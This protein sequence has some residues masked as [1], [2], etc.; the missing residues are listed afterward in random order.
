MTTSP[1]TSARVASASPIGALPPLHS[2]PAP[3][4]SL[5]HCSNFRERQRLH[6]AAL[7][8]RVHELEAA[9]A[10]TAAASTNLALSPAVGSPT[11]PQTLAIIAENSILRNCAISVNFSPSLAPG[12]PGCQTCAVEKARTLIA[13]GQIHCLE[14]RISELMAEN[15]TL[16]TSAGHFSNA[17][18]VSRDFQ[19]SSGCADALMVEP[20]SQPMIVTTN[21]EVSP[22]ALSVSVSSA[23]DEASLRSESS[24]PVNG[25]GSSVCI[26]DL[27]ES[28]KAT[29]KAI[30][31]LKNCEFVEKL[32]DCYMQ[33]RMLTDEDDFYDGCILFKY[34]RSKVIDLCTIVEQ[35]DVMEAL[36]E[37]MEKDIDVPPQDFLFREK[38]D[39]ISDPV[40]RAEKIE[41]LDKER[42]GRVSAARAAFLSI[43]S[44]KNM[45]EY[46]DDFCITL[47][48][49]HSA[50]QAKEKLLR[51]A[52]KNTLYQALKPEDTLQ[53]RLLI[54]ALRKGNRDVFDGLMAE[55]FS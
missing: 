52:S 27:V 15:H 44:L 13:L 21:V 19:D 3:L 39:L 17:V 29:L 46:V 37:M 10:A 24:F 48:T 42:G 28:A 31:A 43:P 12:T 8:A 11:D 16:R 54:E 14:T 5:T 47:F 2:A 25:L 7:E 38:F 22:P 20:S 30:P 51:I 26:S 34:Y 36:S 53:F 41:K 4:P 9:I 6:V 55:V 49:K 18:L 33:C 50:G 45:D 40:V 23:M 35:R 1:K 32:F